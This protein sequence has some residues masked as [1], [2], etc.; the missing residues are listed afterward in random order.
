MAVDEHRTRAALPPFAS[1]FSS[2]QT[3]LFAKDIKKGP[4]RLDEETPAPPID[5]KADPSLFVLLSGLRRS[6]GCDPSRTRRNYRP[7]PH[8][9]EEGSTA[10]PLLAPNLFLPFFFLLHE[11]VLPWLL[12]GWV[13][14]SQGR[15]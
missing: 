3:H 6:C 13:S 10:D 4:S 7:S 9:L 5:P 12:R 1:H 2:R 15:L 11:W 14:N 8:E